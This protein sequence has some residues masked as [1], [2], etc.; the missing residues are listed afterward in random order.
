MKNEEDW[1]ELERDL[2][3]VYRWS[4]TW[5]MEFNA[6][7][8]HIMKFEASKNRPRKTYKMGREKIKVVQKEK[9]ECKDTRYPILQETQTV[10]NI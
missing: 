9:D 5:G 4:Q 7:K 1:E 3:I 2:D 8:S 6:N 10:W